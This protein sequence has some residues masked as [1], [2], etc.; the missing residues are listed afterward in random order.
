VEG[1]GAA[2]LAALR[3]YASDRAKIGQRAVDLSREQ[4]AFITGEVGS[5]ASADAKANAAANALNA[6]LTQSERASLRSAGIDPDTGK[7]IPLGPIDPNAPKNQPKPRARGSRTAA[8]GGRPRPSRPQ[9]GTRSSG[10]SQRRT[11]TRRPARTATSRRSTSSPG[12]PKSSKPVYDTVEIKKNG[13]V[14]GH[15]QVKRLNP[16]G[17]PVT[18]DD[19]GFDAAKSQLLA[20]VAL[21]MAYDGHISRRNQKLLHARGI[22]LKPLGLVTFGE[23]LKTPEGK[24][25]RKA[26][27]RTPAQAANPARDRPG[28]ESVPGDPRPHLGRPT[29]GPSWR[30]AAD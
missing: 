13:K 14:V 12:A 18:S 27:R 19:P 30:R 26:R 4:G 15:K 16:D 3:D 8:R 11:T 7:P 24:A 10:S 2:K 29:L 22:Q 21:D 5:M 9:Q 23:W 20:S 25:W 1:E 17:T 6:R 28:P